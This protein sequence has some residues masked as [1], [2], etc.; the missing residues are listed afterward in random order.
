MFTQSQPVWV[1]GSAAWSAQTV[2]STLLSQSGMRL[3]YVPPVTSKPLHF[4]PPP[5]PQ[6]TRAGLEQGGKEMPPPGAT[7]SPPQKSRPGI[8]Q[9]GSS[10]TLILVPRSLVEVQAGPRTNFK[11][12]T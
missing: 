3:M 12:Q 1:I 2:L 4:L 6:S 7:R 9:C 5:P 10:E 11:S 8:L